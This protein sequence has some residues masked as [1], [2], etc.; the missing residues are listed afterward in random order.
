LNSP[1][2]SARLAMQAASLG[3]QVAGRVVNQ[4]AGGVEKTIG[5]FEEILEDS[6]PVKTQPLS[7]GE[8]QSLINR[9]GESVKKSLES[10]GIVMNPP[11]ELAVQVDGEVRVTNDHPDAARI[12]TA[13][14][15]N[16]DILDQLQQIRNVSGVNRLIVSK[17]TYLSA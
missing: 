3:S 17:S 7:A 11:I 8:L 12:E 16:R 5:L 4:V 6:S 2:T 15:G 1:I 14:S 9:V 10:I 13:L